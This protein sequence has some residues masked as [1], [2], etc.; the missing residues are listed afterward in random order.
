MEIHILGCYTKLSKDLQPYE[1]LYEFLIWHIGMS[2]YKSNP[3]NSFFIT[4]KYVFHVSDFEVYFQALMFFLGHLEESEL[5]MSSRLATMQP[6][7]PFGDKNI[8]IFFR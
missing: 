8:Q 6:R 7:W 1:S 4:I 2:S 5:R 3:Q